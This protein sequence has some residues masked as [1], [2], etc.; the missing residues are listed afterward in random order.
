M[1]AER[2]EGYQHNPQLISER[3]VEDIFNR[4]TGN[5]QQDMDCLLNELEQKNHTLD[6]F[7]LSF[8]IFR[9]RQ[10]GWRMRIPIEGSQTPNIDP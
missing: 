10:I 5:P 6:I 9:M 3:A 2:Q 7:Y 8:Q 1:I 4:L